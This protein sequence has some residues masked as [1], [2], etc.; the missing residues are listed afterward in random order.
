[1][2]PKGIFD[3]T[4]LTGF[5]LSYFGR[6]DFNMAGDLFNTTNLDLQ[7]HEHGDPNNLDRP[8][9]LQPPEDGNQIQPYQGVEVLGK[10]DGLSHLR[11]PLTAPMTLYPGTLGRGKSYFP[12]S[13]VSLRES[14]IHLHHRI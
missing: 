4:G 6:D 8:W 10:L 1:M 13:T 7:N 12:L 14:F 3:F 5:G 9:Y 11:D 2:S